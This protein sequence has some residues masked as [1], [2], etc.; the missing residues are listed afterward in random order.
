MTHECPA[1]G[2]AQAVSAGQLMCRPH[3]QMVDRPLQ[4]AVW[5][6]YAN[7]AGMGSRAHREA[8]LTAIQAVNRKLVQR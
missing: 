7:G 8:I 5:D 1:K 3:W 4:R 2:C 6:A